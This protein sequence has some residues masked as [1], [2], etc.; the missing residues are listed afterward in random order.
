MPTYAPLVWDQEG[1]RPYETGVDQGVLW[2]FDSSANSGAGAWQDGV[3]W[4][5]LTAVTEKP[6]GA[7]PTPQ[8]ADNIKYLNLISAE[9]FGLTI[10][11]F[12]F[13]DEFKICDG[14][15][16]MDT[17]GALTIGQQKRDMRYSCISSLS[18]AVHVIVLWFILS[19]TT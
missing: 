14:T 9:E 7:E 5:G 12:F 6:S 18:M 2:V 10:E 8:Y 19:V 4:N 1:Q 11:A 13:P 15:A 3:A 16:A 17:A